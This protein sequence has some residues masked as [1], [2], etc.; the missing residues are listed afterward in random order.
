MRCSFKW[1]NFLKSSVG[2]IKEI[3]KVAVFATSTILVLSIIFTGIGYIAV[4][5]FGITIAIQASSPFEYYKDI[6][7]IITLFLLL[8][9]ALTMAIYEIRQGFTICDEDNDGID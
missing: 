2:T 5:L 8:L 4:H 6:G 1:R 7:T 9:F 3:V